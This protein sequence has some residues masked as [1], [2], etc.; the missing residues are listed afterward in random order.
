M[1]RTIGADLRERLA[2]AGCYPKRVAPGG[3][4]IWFSPHLNCEFTVERHIADAAAANAT[5]RRAGMEDAF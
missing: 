5:L 2:M 4:E 1:T 3:S